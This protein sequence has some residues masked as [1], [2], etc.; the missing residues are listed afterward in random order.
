MPN[1]RLVIYVTLLSD[2]QSVEWYAV[3]DDG[4]GRTDLEAEGFS[5]CWNA[6]LA[7]CAS[8]LEWQR[9]MMDEPSPSTNRSSS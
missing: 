2:L 8:L 5:N 3:S 4:Y 7:V 1:K 6:T 9:R